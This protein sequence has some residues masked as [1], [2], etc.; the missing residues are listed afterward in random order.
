MAIQTN[1]PANLQA[2]AGGACPTPQPAVQTVVVAPQADDCGNQPGCPSP[3]QAPTILDGDNFFSTAGCEILMC[4]QNT[5]TTA[6]PIYIGLDAQRGLYPIFPDIAASAVDATTVLSCD[7]LYANA[8]HAPYVDRINTL[9]ASRTLFASRVFVR[10]NATTEGALNSQAMQK[11]TRIQRYWSIDSTCTSV[12]YEPR[13]VA[14]CLGSDLTAGN[15]QVDFQGP[16][17]FDPFN[18]IKYTLNGGST[19]EFGICVSGQS[20]NVTAYPCGA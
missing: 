5:G 17:A 18:G 6:V 19:I 2:W 7:T 10:I 8:D 15:I 14:R 11:L 9:T 16:F 13:C 1:N 4:L 20:K 12:Q 3:T